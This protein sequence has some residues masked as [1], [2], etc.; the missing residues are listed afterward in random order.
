MPPRYSKQD[1]NLSRQRTLVG[2]DVLERQVMDL[3]DLVFRLVDELEATHMKDTVHYARA[4]SWL[5]TH[6]DKAGSEYERGGNDG[7][8]V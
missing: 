5:L 4:A 3:T 1:A 7:K 2:V 6:V 8:A